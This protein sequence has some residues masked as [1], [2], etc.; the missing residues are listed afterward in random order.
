MTDQYYFSLRS[1][2]PQIM[3]NL[4][5]VSAVTAFSPLFDNE[6]E[7]LPLILQ[8]HKQI[9]AS[10]IANT[11]TITNRDQNLSHVTT[12]VFVCT[13]LQFLSAVEEMAMEIA[14]KRSLDG[15]NINES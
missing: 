5:Q 2:F 4:Q 12:E 11:Y 14:R 10:Q 1:R 9:I 6:R 7:I 3:K 15:L 13:P 8:E